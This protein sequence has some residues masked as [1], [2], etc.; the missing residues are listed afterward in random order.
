MKKGSIYLL[1]AKREENPSQGTSRDQ[2]KGIFFGGPVFDI[3]LNYTIL[4][5]FR[6]KGRIR[7]GQMDENR[8][9]RIMERVELK[10][11][12]IIES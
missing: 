1:L 7:E 4:E 8:K 5:E 11:G 12:R 6:S 10:R 2:R 9:N 3:Q